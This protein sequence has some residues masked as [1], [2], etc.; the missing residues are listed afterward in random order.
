MKNAFLILAVSAGLVLS[1]AEPPKVLVFSRCEGYR[2]GAAIEACCAA[3]AEASA[4]GRYAVDFTNE[5]AA[6][7][8]GNL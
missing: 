5:Y 2:H 7:A 6:L 3:L 1:A 8:I 4:A